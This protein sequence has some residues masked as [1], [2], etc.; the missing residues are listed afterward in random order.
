MQGV[1][2]ELAPHA[3]RPNLVFALSYHSAVAAET[4]FEPIALRGPVQ[5]G[6]GSYATQ[7]IGGL[8][9]NPPGDRFDAAMA[10]HVGGRASW[11][12]IGSAMLMFIPLEVVLCL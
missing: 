6:P 9:L 7:L 4:N 5:F 2:R 1:Q 12:L 8:T 10:L 11:I 3:A